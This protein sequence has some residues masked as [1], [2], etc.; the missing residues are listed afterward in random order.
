V[1]ALVDLVLPATCAGC[2]APGLAACAA[3]LSPLTAAA[4]LR[5]P[6]PVPPGLPPPYVVASYA[7]PTRKLL[8]AFKADGVVGLRA[9]LGA[10]LAVAVQHALDRHLPDGA[11]VWLVPAP[12]SRSSRQRRGDDVVARLSRLAAAT[13]RRRGWQVRVLPALRHGRVV[14][15]SAG[16]TATER[17]SNLAEALDVHA[18]TVDLLRRYPVVLTGDLVTTGATLAEA[19]RA[20]R[21]VGGTVL[22]AATV[23]ATERRIEDGSHGPPQR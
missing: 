18:S 14:R 1:R 11:P 15:D 4:R 23:A 22:A 12:S 13:C 7:G 3:C 20:I 17:A 2:G 21:A 8:V 16:L 6:R 10:A 19:A 5:W 9:P